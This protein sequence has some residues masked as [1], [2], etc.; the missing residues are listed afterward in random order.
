MLNC[1]EASRLCSESLD[2][3]LTLWQR[4]HLWLHLAMCRLCWHYRRDIV[5]LHEQARRFDEEV[6]EAYGSKPTGGLS[7]EARLRIKQALKT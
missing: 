5:H 3:K 4:A 7:E 2:R 1:H 6:E